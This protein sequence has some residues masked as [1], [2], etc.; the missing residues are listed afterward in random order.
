MDTI[1]TGIG[2][3]LLA[4]ALPQPKAGPVATLAVPAASLLPAVG[5]SIIPL[6]HS[7]AGRGFN[8]AISSP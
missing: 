4:R 5:R 8:P 6:K 2:G 1:T 7:L 3:A